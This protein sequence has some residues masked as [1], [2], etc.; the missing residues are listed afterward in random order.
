MLEA[1]MSLGLKETEAGIKLNGAL[2]N[3][4]R[5]ADDL[6]IFTGSRPEQQVHF[7]Y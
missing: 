7:G 6:D 4:L 3:H 5:F 2:L 1:V